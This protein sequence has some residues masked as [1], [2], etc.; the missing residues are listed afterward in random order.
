MYQN[1]KARVLTPSGETEQFD[2]TTGVMQGDT[3]PPFL[4][5]VVL[6]YALRGALSGYQE[7]LGFTISTRRSQRQSTVTLTD[8]DF[9]N[10]IAL[11]S[12]KIKQAQSIMSRVQRELQNVGLALNAKKT[13]YITYNIDTEGTAVKTNDGI[14][15]E[16]EEDFK[17]LGSWIDST[18]KDI[19]IRK[20]QAWQ[21]LNKMN[22][23][24]NSNMR[25]EIKVGFFVA[26]IE[27]ILLYGCESWTVTPD[28]ECLLNVTYTKML[29]KATDVKWWE[30]MTNAEVYEELPLGN[31]ITAKRMKLAGH[32]H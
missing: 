7:Q 31:K 26:A 17:Y 9:A 5:I 30:C 22:C 29:R 14:E 8:L 3:L 15:L 11:L 10:D 20:A 19:K 4:S 6:D 25:K 1:T 16:K 21:A 24:W 12:D 28:I 23:I 13:K 2:I 27:S 32:C 18:D